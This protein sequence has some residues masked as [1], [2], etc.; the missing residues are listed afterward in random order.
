LWSANNNGLTLNMC[1]TAAGQRGQDFLA[2]LSS[3]IGARVKGWDDNFEIRPCGKEFTA[4]P[5]KQVAQTG[6][7]GR[8]AYLECA[9]YDNLAAT[10]RNPLTAA[11][12]LWNVGARVLGVK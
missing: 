5:D 1:R 9:Y 2:E 10:I 11:R 6:D 8:T 7:T 3:L 4:T 12:A